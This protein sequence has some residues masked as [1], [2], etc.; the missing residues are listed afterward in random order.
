LRSIALHAGRFAPG[1]QEALFYQLHSTRYGATLNAVDDW[2]RAASGELSRLGYRLGGRR[3][4]FPTGAICSWVAAGYGYRGAVLMTN[5]R[6]LYPGVDSF[7][8]HAIALTARAD[9]QAAS[10]LVMVDPLPTR[11]APR[12]P[13]TSLEAAHRDAR[14]GTIVFYWSG[15]S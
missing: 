7:A 14:L 1:I 5:P 3:V 13:P 8:D 6:K 15:W 11:G 12:S 4:A 9:G 2:L 10:T